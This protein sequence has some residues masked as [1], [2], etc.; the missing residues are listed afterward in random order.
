M[1]NG[2]TVDEPG[3]GREVRWRLRRV[4]ERLAEIEELK[5]EV[6]AYEIHQINSKVDRLTGVVIKVGISIVGSAIV[7]AFTVFALI[8]GPQ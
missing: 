6:M 8:G 2:V 3:N 4:E 7:F 1:G 5:P